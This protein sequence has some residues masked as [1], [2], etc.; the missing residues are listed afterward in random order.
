MECED[1]YK[2]YK[3]DEPWDGPNNRRLASKMPSVYICP[4][5]IARY[6][7]NSLE[8]QYLAVVG[9]ETVWPGASSTK[10]SDITDAHGQTIL[11][12]EVHGQGV[13]WMEPRDVTMQETINL[14]G[15]NAPISSTG[16]YHESVFFRHYEP[17]RCVAYVDGH[18]GSLA[19]RIDARS[20][21][22]MCTKSAG[23]SLESVQ[24]FD[25][26]QPPS[27]VR[28]EGVYA[29]AVFC[30][31]AILPFPWWAIREPR[32]AGRLANSQATH[33]GSSSEHTSDAGTT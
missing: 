23:D 19:Y 6:G 20:I 3:F 7:S 17:R 18:V 8:T 14:L 27:E 2:A 29:F 33:D 13:N 12:L 26:L 1:I 32:Q 28:W 5:H 31:L 22:T 16:H 10:L 25:T 9:P 11:F 4:G 24:Q 30:L 15:P 21:R